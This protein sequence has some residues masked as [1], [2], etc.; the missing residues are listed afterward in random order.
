MEKLYY[1]TEEW[2]KARQKASNKKP[3]KKFYGLIPNPLACLWVE[4]PNQLQI[5]EC[6]GGGGKNLVEI[7]ERVYVYVRG[8]NIP[9][10]PDKL[11][12]IF[13]CILAKNAKINR[14]NLCNYYNLIKYNILSKKKSLKLHKNQMT[15]NIN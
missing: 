13:I 15:F 8:R 6:E 10:Y 2:A 5:W 4:Y 1:S 12:S 11:Y 9:H 3:R 7:F 14:Q